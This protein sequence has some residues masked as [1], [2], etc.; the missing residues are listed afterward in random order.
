M[1]LLRTESNSNRTQIEPEIEIFYIHRT[2]TEPELSCF[3]LINRIELE[4]KK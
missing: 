4:P 3:K 1:N 2:R